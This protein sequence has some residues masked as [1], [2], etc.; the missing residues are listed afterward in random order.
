VHNFFRIGALLVIVV[1]AFAAYASGLLERLQPEALRDLLVD[2]GAWGPLVFIAL[3]SGLG[4]FGVPG[5]IFLLTAVAVWPPWTAF[6]FCWL[7]GM[8]AGIVGFGFARTIGRDWV[9]RQLPH[10][11]R[12]FEVRLAERGLRTVIMVRLLFFLFAPSHWM[13]GL[14]PVKLGPFLLGSA[15]GFLPWTAVWVLAGEGAILA[16]R[17]QPPEVWLGI[18]GLVLL[19]LLV[20][21]M[22]ARPPGRS[23]E[24]TGRYPGSST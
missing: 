2:S 23:A 7:G 12:Q 18:V 19:V 14:S 21:R 5:A 15:I 4:P 22:R 10:R 8:G 17:D 1:A 13:L 3:F 20:R 24:N 16:M 9:A 6:L 11:L